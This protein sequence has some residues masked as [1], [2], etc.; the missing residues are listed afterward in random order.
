MIGSLRPFRSD[1]CSHGINDPGSRRQNSLII[2]PRGA[3][4][5][6]IQQIEAL[7]RQPR[8]AKARQFELAKPWFFVNAAR[9]TDVAGINEQITV[10]LEKEVGSKAHD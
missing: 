8:F 5:P 10:A 7:A 3:S 1:T 9:L 2:I 4:V 6:D